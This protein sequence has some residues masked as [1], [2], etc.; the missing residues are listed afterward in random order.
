MS[1]VRQ[2][3]GLMLAAAALVFLAGCPGLVKPETINQRI[4]YSEAALT[5]AYETIGNLKT[6]GRIDAAKRDSLVREADKAGIAVDAARAA[7]G[8]GLPN[9]ALGRLQVAQAIL[10]TLQK[11]LEELAP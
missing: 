7:L 3:W 11:T 2:Y 6:S 10:V 5:A 9:D 4:A 8:K 1:P